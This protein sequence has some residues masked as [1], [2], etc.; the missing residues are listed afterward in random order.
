MPTRPAV[1]RALSRALLF[2]L[3]LLGGHAR[4]GAIEADSTVYHAGVVRLVLELGAD[5]TRLDLPTPWIEPRTFALYHGDSLLTRGVDYLLDPKA[6]WLRLLRHY[7]PGALFRVAYRAFPIPLRAEYRRHRPLLPSEIE[8]GA[9]ADSGRTRDSSQDPFDLARLDLSGSKTFSVEVGTAQDLKLRQSLDLTVRGQIAR[10]VSVRAILTDRDTPLQ[11]DGTSSA[12][13]DLDRVLL[14]VEG[15]RARMTLGDF[16][17]SLA[18]GEFARYQRE[19]EGAEAEAMPGKGALFATGATTPGEFSTIEFL[20]EE[21]KQ[22]PY[23]LQSIDPTTRGAI[24]AGSERVSLDGARLTRGESADYIIDYSEGTVTFTGRRVITAYSRIAVDFQVLNEAFRRSVYGGGGGLGAVSRFEV[25]RDAGGSPAGQIAPPVDVWQGVG[26][27]SPVPSSAGSVRASGLGLYWL[28]ERDD[29]NRPLGAPLTAE[30][31]AALSVAGDSLTDALR[32]GIEFV[33]E[34]GGEYEKVE[35]DT[36]LTP[37]FLYVGQGAGAWLVR[38]DQVGEG[39]GDYADTTDVAD[40]RYF[41]FVGR[42]QGD[43]LAGREVPRPTSTD[44]VSVVGSTD[45]LLGVGLRGELALSDF[46]QNRFS[47]RDDDDNRGVAFSG[48]ARSSPLDVGGTKVVLYGKKREVD[49]RFRSLDRLDPAFFGLDWNL[50]A[51]RLASGDS[52]STLGTRFTR[53]ASELGLEGQTLSNRENF[54]AQ[55]LQADGRVPLGPLRLSGRWLEARSRDELDSLRVHGRRRNSEASLGLPGSLVDARLRY[56]GERTARGSGPT[57]SGDLFHEGGLRV[58]SGR[59]FE[60]TQASLEWTLRDSWVLEGPRQRRRDRGQTGQADLSF[61]SASGQSASALYA[62]RILRPEGSGERQT[63][64]QGR[65]RWYVRGIHEAISQEGRFEL[66]SVAERQRLKE[67]R[68]VG[69]GEGHYDSLGVYQGVGDYDLFYREGASEA[70]RN[71]LEASFRTELDLE[72]SLAKT[73]GRGTPLRRFIRTLRVTQSWTA[74][75]DSDRPIGYLSARFVPVLLALRDQPRARADLRTDL[76]ALPNARVFSPRLRLELSRSTTRPATDYREEDNRRL[77]AL[78][79]RSRPT[80]RW[81][82][83][84]EPELERE[85]HRLETGA[86]RATSGWSSRRL[87][88]DQDLSVNGG[89]SLGL[90]TSLRLRDRIASRESVTVYEATSSLLVSPSRRSR[91]ELSTTR[92]SLSRRNGEGRPDRALERP[93]WVGRF[94]SSFRLKE[95]LDLS[96]SLR[97]QKPD[98]G[99]EVREARMELR[100]TF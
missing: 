98:D 45:R 21:G 53:G 90:D 27:A 87:R 18:G 55:R 38:F 10:N 11:P 58:A 44:L 1:S 70:A 24:V 5:S 37:F 88:C 57:R 16:R 28:S 71:R 6:G 61:S 54:D 4:A 19:L 30:E 75:V 85:E 84:V 35:N 79:L 99:R 73:D 25:G 95:S 7:A 2:W 74:Q 26:S 50:D 78:R 41:V 29:R 96:A 77:L 83:D 20:G 93:G 60:R 86:T 47:R 76:S 68:F 9:P 94:L 3:A 97:E 66:S 69:E 89:V 15:P 40:H 31:K 46:D 56:R 62:V 49:R 8:H 67:I 80:S 52:R 34:G 81:S 17:L 22:G 64:H 63:S 91:I 51:A 72:R 12:L 13:S 39:E 23:R 48:E 82:I 59:R 43:Y 14:E 36:L 92:T 100:A 32:S 65:L 42:K 33:G